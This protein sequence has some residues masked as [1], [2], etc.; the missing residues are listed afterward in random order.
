[1]I[2]AVAESLRSLELRT[3]VM[4][5]QQPKN[6][7]FLKGPTTTKKGLRPTIKHHL[8]SPLGDPSTL[9]CRSLRAPASNSAAS[10][11]ATYHLKVMVHVHALKPIQKGEMNTTIYDYVQ[12]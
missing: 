4:G 5:I 10:A 8:E 12:I 1:M 9:Q 11:Q 6:Q 7:A 3:V 2:G